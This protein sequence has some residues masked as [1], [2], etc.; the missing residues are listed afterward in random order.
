MAKAFERVASGELKRLIINMPPRHT[1]SEFESHL[2]PAWFLGKYPD[3]YVIQASNT[4][5]LAVDFG[6]K[7]R[8]TISDDA[9]HEIFPNVS[10]HPDAAAAGKWKTT[11]KGEYFAIGTGGPR[12]GR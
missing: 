4:A 11:A 3:K 2:F 12:P 7:V 6:R 9:Y 1:K 10:I 8:D 5:D